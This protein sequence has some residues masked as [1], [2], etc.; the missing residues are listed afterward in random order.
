MLVAVTFWRKAT[1]DS[2]NHS[3]IKE[4]GLSSIHKSPWYY[5]KHIK[6]NIPVVNFILD[7]ILMSIA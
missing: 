2:Q 7:K 4:T 6:L 3:H 1:E 5:H